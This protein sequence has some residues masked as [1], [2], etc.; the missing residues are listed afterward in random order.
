[1]GSYRRYSAC[2]SFPPLSLIHY[3]GKKNCG[4]IDILITRPSDDG[5]THKRANFKFL[6]RC[7][8]HRFLGVL[9]RLLQE[10]HATGILTEDLAVPEDPDDLEAIYRGLCRIPKEGSKRRRI[11]FLTVPWR[12]RGAALL[13]YTVSMLLDH[14]VLRS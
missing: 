4:D 7:V 12:S 9:P 11:D 14:V 2:D 10:L 1:M 6:G 8:A 5:M 3:R 13:Y